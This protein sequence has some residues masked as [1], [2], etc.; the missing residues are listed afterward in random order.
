MVILAGGLFLVGVPISAAVGLVVVGVLGYR[1]SADA[2]EL[3]AL[4]ILFGSIVLQA[5]IYFCVINNRLPRMKKN[6][7]ASSTIRTGEEPNP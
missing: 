2:S 5:F 3:G 4:L 6:Q 1:E 7:S